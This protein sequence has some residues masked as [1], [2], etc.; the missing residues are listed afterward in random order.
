MNKKSVQELSKPASNENAAGDFVPASKRK[1]PD[2]GAIYAKTD[3]R[4]WRNRLFR[5]SYHRNGQRHEVADWCIK[6]AHAGRRETINLRTA[7]QAAAV[8]KAAD[9]YRTLV[10]SGWDAVLDL[11]KPKPVKVPKPATVGEFIAAASSLATARPVSVWEYAGALR[12]I[13]ADVA[14]LDRS[15]RTKW[16]GRTGGAQAW[17]DKVDA[18]PLSCLTPSA[19]HAWRLATLKKAGADLAKQ[20]AAKTTINSVIRKANCLFAR[21]IIRHLDRS[22]MLPPHPF[23][24][25]EFFER[26]S[27]RYESK[28]DAAALIAAA[29]EELGGDAS[30][31]ELW[32]A[33]VLLMFAGLRRN[34][35]DKLRWASVD[36]AAGLLRIEDHEHFQPKCE[37]SK[38]AVELDGE[39]IAMMRGWRAVDPGLYVLRSRVAPVT[40]ANQRRYRAN[41]TFDALMAWLRGHGI[42]AEK[43]LH[44][45]RKEAGS[46]VAQRHGIF[47]ASRFLR[48]SD[49]KLTS[50]HY[51]D[52]KGRVTVGLGGLLNESPATDAPE[53][54]ITPFPAPVKLAGS[55]GLE[56]KTA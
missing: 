52:K 17:R 26:Q 24:E 18:L 9:I 40:T 33:F 32:K 49:I 2:S 31:L 45:L 28:I 34:E 4:Y 8:Q 55:Q 30:K 42:T 43:A 47:A 23:A 19:V 36:F 38:G 21:K 5:N 16:A 50:A 35:A 1:A 10:S 20:R 39:V 6:I 15:D 13:V 22:L 11:C 27:M 56:R 7:N 25:V 14:G 44:E 3:V 12:Q 29:R 53:S 41:R 48:H 46:V 37:T 54:N 51:V